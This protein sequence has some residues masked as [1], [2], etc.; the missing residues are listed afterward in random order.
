IVRKTLQPLLCAFI[1][2]LLAPG[3]MAEETKPMASSLSDLSIEQLMNESVTSVSKKETKLNQS[4]AA[5]AVVTQEDIRR[6]GITSIP[7]ALRWVPGMDVGRI[8][9]HTW[10]VSA[11]GFESHFGN[12]LL[13]LIDGRAIYES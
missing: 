11:R 8:D 4:P 2:A 12:K 3:A 9:S 10:A 7:E 6:L 13:V 1:C 5:I